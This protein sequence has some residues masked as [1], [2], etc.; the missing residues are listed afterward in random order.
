RDRARKR[1]PARAA[2][3]TRIWRRGPL[4][5]ALAGVATLVV[6]ASAGAGWALLTLARCTAAI[7]AAH[8]RNLQR[9]ADWAT[10]PLEA[11]V[12]EGRGSWA[13]AFAA[14][15]RRARLGAAMQREMRL[16]LERFR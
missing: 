9:M 14:L 15:H 8:L 13:D 11:P 4:A 10:G 2:A 6:L 1:L 3:M 5:P 12:P 7:V 16:A